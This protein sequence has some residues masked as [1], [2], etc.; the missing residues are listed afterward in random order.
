MTRTYVLSCLRPPRC[1]Q[2]LWGSFP[3]G[4]GTLPPSGILRPPSDQGS[5]TTPSRPPRRVPFPGLPSSSPPLPLPQTK[6]S[7]H[8]WRSDP[9][10]SPGRTVTST[11]STT[12]T[13]YPWSLSAHFAPV[14][15]PRIPSR[16]TG[17]RR[18]V[19]RLLGTL[20]VRSRGYGP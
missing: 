1:P 12:R 3:S 8:L 15:R 5:S 13:S 18:G 4:P 17:S 11:T 9:H 14:S 20:F 16:R 19:H 7:A 10:D 2:E 6:S